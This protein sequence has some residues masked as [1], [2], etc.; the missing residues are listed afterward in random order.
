MVIVN[1]VANYA[2]P[3]RDKFVFEFEKLAMLAG[4]LLLAGSLVFARQLQ[5]VLNFENPWPFAVLVLAVLA[6]VPFYIRGAY[7]RG[8]QLFGQVSVGNILAAG[9]KLVISAILV[10]VGLGTVGAISGVVLAQILACALII[11][12]AYRAVAIQYRHRYR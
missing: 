1:I 12:W 2:E 9:A 5:N 3:Q 8:Q 6:S 4:L 7:L 11:W 10:A